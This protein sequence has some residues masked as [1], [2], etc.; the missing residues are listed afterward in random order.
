MALF[1]RKAYS[2]LVALGD[3]RT[4]RLIASGALVGPA[5]GMTLSLAAV[6]LSPVGIAS[7]LM[8]LSP[9]LLIPLGHWFFHECID[10]PAVMGTTIAWPASP[11]CSALMPGSSCTR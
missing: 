10:A 5:I 1:Q 6:Q 7:T 9:I 8:S 4:F 11:C 2:T 3:P